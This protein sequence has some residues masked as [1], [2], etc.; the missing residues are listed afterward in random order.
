M[1]VCDASGSTAAPAAGASQGGCLSGRSPGFTRQPQVVNGESELLNELFGDRGLVV[2]NPDLDPETGFITA[3]QLDS[4][5]TIE[6][7][8]F[9]DCSGTRGLLIKHALGTGFDDYGRWLPCDRAMAVPSERFEKTL[10]YTRSIA[11]TGGW[12]WRIPLQ[13]RNGNGLVYSSRHYSDDEAADIWLQEIG[14]DPQRFSRIGPKDNF[15]SM[16]DTGPCGPCSEIHLDRGG[17]FGC[18]EPDCQLGCECDRF[19]EIWNLVFMQF[20]RDESGTMTPLPKPSIDTG[21]GLERM[22]AILQNVS[23]NYDTDLL[24]PIITKAENLAEQLRSFTR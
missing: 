1:P 21:L 8:L 23:T 9:V 11:H 15:W 20:N 24:R 6:G 7:D 4:G 16:G 17:G 18:G 10:P 22:V 2:G 19:L 13:H 14:V 5:K 12:Q 3:L